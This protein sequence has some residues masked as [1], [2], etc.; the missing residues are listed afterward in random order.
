MFLSGVFPPALI[1]FTISA[2]V[3]FTTWAGKI[4]AGIPCAGFPSVAY[5]AMVSTGALSAFSIGTEY[6]AIIKSIS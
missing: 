1:A 6:G 3:A 4:V 2:T 5:W